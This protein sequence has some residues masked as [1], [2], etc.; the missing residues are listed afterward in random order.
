M[1]EATQELPGRLDV[2][3]NPPETHETGQSGGSVR[4]SRP[5]RPTSRLVRRLAPPTMTGDRF[6]GR[7]RRRPLSG[8][9][10]SKGSSI[11]KGPRL[12]AERWASFTLRGEWL[13]SVEPRNTAVLIV[14][15]GRP[16]PWPLATL[17]MRL[18]RQKA[19]ETQGE[20]GWERRPVS[21]GAASGS[22]QPALE[23]RQRLRAHMVLNA[24]GVALRHR[25]RNAEGTQE[26]HHRLVA[27][28]AFR[29]QRLALPG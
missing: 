5:G 11:S 23:S 1:F 19:A 26:R 29:S 12:G 22:L 3:A 2:R 24:L 10:P 27:A 8:R 7:G 4:A 28:L 20:K 18:L 25:L 16:L 13:S 15:L 6:M 21:N 14:K 17:S 9:V